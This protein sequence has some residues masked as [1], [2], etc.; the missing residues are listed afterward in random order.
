MEK[1]TK[2]TA[3][4]LIAGLVL[5][6]APAAFAEN[7][8]IDANSDTSVGV[9][10]A[11][12]V[13]LGA[14]TQTNA[15]TNVGATTSTAAGQGTAG[16][17]SAGA[18]AS[19]SAIV[20]TRG[21]ASEDSATVSTASAVRTE[22]DLAAYAATVVRS[23]ENAERADLSSNNVSLRYK[24]RAYLLGIIP[25]YVTVTANV[26]SD[27]SVSVSYPWYGFLLSS[28]ER[29]ELESEL[30]AAVQGTVQSSASLDAE[31]GLTTRA[32]AE[33]LEKVHAALKQN[34]DASV[35]ADAT[36]GASVE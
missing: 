14:Q 18:G 30:N 13:N 5:G 32:K 35:A 4:A 9:N 19:G 16:S 29:A 3:I 25:V 26:E 7:V 31:G 10:D 21:S 23:D 28:G 33:L 34:L 24:Q 12:D 22:T 11:V 6:A 1:I 27:G 36:T 17:G 15:E 20:V 8:Y 2:K